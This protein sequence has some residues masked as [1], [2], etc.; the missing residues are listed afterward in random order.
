MDGLE[1]WR[2]GAR[3]SAIALVWPSLN[4]RFS[5][6]YSGLSASRSVNRTLPSLALR[7]ISSMVPG[8]DYQWKHWLDKPSAPA[9]QL[10]PVERS[11]YWLFFCVGITVRSRYTILLG[12]A[13]GST[14]R[15]IGLVFGSHEGR[16]E[17]GRI[18]VEVL[19]AGARS[20]VQ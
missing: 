9:L 4:G 15:D 3:T 2:T 5:G 7:K 10:F 17:R 16:S 13:L 11:V 18:A 20:E 19:G 8:K 6:T 14:T 12:Y 1:P